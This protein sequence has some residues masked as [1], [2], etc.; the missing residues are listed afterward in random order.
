M[1][2]LFGVPGEWVVQ[3][4]AVGL[5]LLVALM[6]FRGRLVPRSMYDELARDRD[7]WRDVALK[8]IGHADVLMPAAQITTEVARHLSDAAARNSEVRP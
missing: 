7:Q 1:S 3:G 5:L 8:A 2:E 4:G 6:V